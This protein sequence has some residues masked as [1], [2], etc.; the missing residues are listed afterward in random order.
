MQNLCQATAGRGRSYLNL[1][2][3][4]IHCA[5]MQVR[6]ALLLPAPQPLEHVMGTFLA[7][8]AGE[9]T[10]KQPQWVQIC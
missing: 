9:H 4:S 5:A 2:S 3:A 1:R 10:T 6:L 8:M 7:A